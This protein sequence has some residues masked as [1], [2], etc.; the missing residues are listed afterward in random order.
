MKRYSSDKDFNAAIASLVS[1]G[2]QYRTAGK[3]KHAKVIV[4]NGRK[5]TIPY[6]PGDWRA[7]RNFHR[8]AAHLAALP[9]NEAK[10]D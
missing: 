5:M 10:R 4:P 7:I 1:D 6:S 8:N 9:S 3:S 2:W